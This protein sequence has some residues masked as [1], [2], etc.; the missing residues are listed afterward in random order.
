LLNLHASSDN[1]LTASRVALDETNQGLACLSSPMLTSD[2]KTLVCGARDLSSGAL[3]NGQIGFSEYAAATGKIVRV[4][5]QRLAGPVGP[6][7]IWTNAS[8]SV[9]IGAIQAPDFAL[10]VGVITRNGYAFLP[11]SPELSP[12]NVAW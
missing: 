4:L 3:L 2:G 5:G 12:T 8:G 7:L 11:W 9:L 1:L 6:Y 10:S